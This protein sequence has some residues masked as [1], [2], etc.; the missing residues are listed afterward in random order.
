MCCRLI[1]KKMQDLYQKFRFYSNIIALYKY[2]IVIAML[3]FK[4]KYLSTFIST[5]NKIQTLML[6]MLRS[7]RSHK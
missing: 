6:Q 4:L 2:I 1:M 5:N 3:M 7:Y